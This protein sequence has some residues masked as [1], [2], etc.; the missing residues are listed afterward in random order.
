MQKQRVIRNKPTTLETHLGRPM[1]HTQ[2]FIILVGETTQT[3]DGKINKIKA[4]IRDVTT[5]TTMWLTNIPHRDYIS[6]HLTT[7]LNIHIKIKMAILIPPT[8]TH[9]HPKIDSQ[10]LR[11]YL[12]A[13][14]KKFKTVKY[15]ERKCGPICRIKMLPSRN[16]RH[17]LATYSSKFP[18]ITCAATPIQTQERNVK[19][20]PSEVGRN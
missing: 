12:N 6:T 3:L 5:P 20:S 9:H 11:L 15:F 17:K 14:A 8:P 16:L 7:P 4:K 19:L 18:A 13:Y 10:G 2:K 1:I